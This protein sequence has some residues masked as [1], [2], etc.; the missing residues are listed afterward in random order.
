MLISH[1]IGELES[2]LLQCFIKAGKLKQWFSRPNCPRVIRECKELF[3]NAY[4]PKSQDNA[5]TSDRGDE[6]FVELPADEDDSLSSQTTTPPDLNRLI[7]QNKV[8]LHARHKKRGII[9]SR[10]STHLG[11]SL[12]HFYANGQSNELVPG[13]IKYIFSSQGR[14][15]FAVQR[16][17]PL[18][19]GIKDPFANW[20]H[21]P[22]KLYSPQ[23]RGELEIVELDWIYAHYARWTISQWLAVVLSLSRV[24]LRI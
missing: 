22:A 23:L 11:N 10:S 18:R 2:T 7:H 21:F 3:D 4:A 13:S 15:A 14:T 17:L 1:L 16:Q 5:L 8:V 24:C 20:P 12:I 6:I 9:Y 19:N